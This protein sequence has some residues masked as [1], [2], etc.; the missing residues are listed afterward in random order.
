M[1]GVDD[2]SFRRGRTFGTI[3]VDG[4]RHRVL[5][6][7]PDRAQITFALWLKN[8][9]EVQVISRDRGGDYAAGGFANGR[10]K[11]PLSEEM[12]AVFCP[13]LREKWFSRFHNLKKYLPSF[14]I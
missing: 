3:L 12:L 2:F 13:I 11:L 14:P 6:L 10:R 1:L 5:A 7:L 4:A 9:P 8:H